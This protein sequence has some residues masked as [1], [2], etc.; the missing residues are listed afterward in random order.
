MKLRVVACVAAAAIAAGCSSS[1]GKPIPVGD[2]A[3]SASSA[4]AGAAYAVTLL[5][6]LGGAVASANSANRNRVL[7]GTA[8]LAGDSVARAALWR[9]GSVADLGTLGGDNSAVAWPNHDAGSVVGIA[10]TADLNPAGENWSCAPFFAS[11][12]PTHHICLG[13]VWKN[14]AMLPLPTLG[15]PD[16]YAAGSNERGD[17][18]GWAETTVHDSTCNAPQVYQFEAVVWDARGEVTPLPPLSGDPDSAATAI[19]DRGDVV[20]I[21][22][23]CDNAVGRFSAIHAVRWERG[24]VTDLGN[25]G[26]GAWNTPTAINDR[27]DVVGFADLPGSGGHLHPHAFEWTQAA[28]IKD[29]GTLPGDTYSYATGINNR[30]QVVGFSYSA[31]TQRAF[32]WQNGKMTDLNSVVPAG[33]PYLLVAND[34][35]DDG[36]IAGQAYDPKT[37]TTPAFSATATGEIESTSTASMATK[38]AI[39]LPARVLRMPR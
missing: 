38:P 22:G 31:T 10:E 7:S 19:N 32:I 2:R 13:F 4:R 30:G 24:M 37:Q 8:N 26:G 15:G 11:G 12:Q 27:G 21:S 1:G 23:R 35:G 28:G 34:I 14:G 3:S 25:I 6:G 9:D 36:T 39:A 18:V 33:S 20:G 5:P 16:G 29:L 17:V